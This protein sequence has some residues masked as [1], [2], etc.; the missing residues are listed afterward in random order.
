MV[1]FLFEQIFLSTLWHL[2]IIWNKFF[3]SDLFFFLNILFR[4]FEYL[5]AIPN[6]NLN[7]I[8]MG[9]KKFYELLVIKQ[10]RVVLNKIVC[11]NDGE[12]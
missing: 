3:A 6:L 5:I 9:K 10:L 2:H 7:L 8:W 4:S 11:W 1:W 12:E